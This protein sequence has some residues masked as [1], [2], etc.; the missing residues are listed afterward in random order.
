MRKKRA[1]RIRN[2]LSEQDRREQILSGCLGE[3]AKKGVSVT[4]RDLAYAARVSEALLFK[5]FPSKE[6]LFRSLEDRVFNMVREGGRLVDGLK[7]SSESLIQMTCLTFLFLSE[8]LPH[9]K[10]KEMIDRVVVQSLL[11]D[12]RLYRKLIPLIASHIPFLLECRRV[13]ER[14]GDYQY[15]ATDMT[16]LCWFTQHLAGA[17]QIYAP[18]H[19]ESYRGGR[20]G[21]IEDAIRFSLLGTGMKI[22]IVD[23][24]LDYRK[25]RAS[26]L[27]KAGAPAAKTAR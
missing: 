3:F 18:H 11:A 26:I 17:L 24:Y 21:A 9:W 7:P 4:T 10:E 22:E 8:G 25:L 13:G 14:A 23:K 27:R 5:H 15:R 20:E 16:N 12:G 6:D 2:R 19:S 1:P